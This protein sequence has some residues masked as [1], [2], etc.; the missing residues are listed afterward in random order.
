MKKTICNYGL[1]VAIVALIFAFAI[2]FWSFNDS[3]YAYEYRKSD[4]AN[5]VGVSEDTLIE[6]S[7]YLFN[8]LKGQHEDLDIVVEI[9]G[10]KAPFYTH[11]DYLHM[12]DVKDLYQNFKF[13]SMI[14]LVVAIALSIYLYLSKSSLS[15]FY[16]AYKKALMVIG[17]VIGACLFMMVIDFRNFWFYFHFLLFD[18]DLWLISPSESN[19]IILMNQTL[20]NDLLFLITFS[21]IIMLSVLSLGLKYFIKRKEKL[22]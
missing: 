1:A 5:E 22:L 18:N 20:F 8:Y 7:D 9:N 15:I 13:F 4:V 21:I 17:A 10:H 2:Q 11:R 19:L 16:N 14:A 12:E 3:F 6:S